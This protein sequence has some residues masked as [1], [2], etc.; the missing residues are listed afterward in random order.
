[1]GW[2][3][4]QSGRLRTGTTGLATSEGLADSVSRY[5]AGSPLAA[6]SRAFSHPRICSGE[7]RMHFSICKNGSFP[8]LHHCDNAARVTFNPLASSDGVMRSPE[9]RRVWSTCY[10]S[11]LF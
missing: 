10:S 7:K 8:C 5:H 6:R 1:M 2:A 4:L 9:L 11:L 3:M